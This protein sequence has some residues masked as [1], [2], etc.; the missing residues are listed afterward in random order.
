MKLGSYL[1]PEALRCIKLL[2]T[3]IDSENV[4]KH[5]TMSKVIKATQKV[6]A[7]RKKVTGVNQNSGRGEVA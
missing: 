1:E 3:G 5:Q 7:L 6:I 4:K 2:G